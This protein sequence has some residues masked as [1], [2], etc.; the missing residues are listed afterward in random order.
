[1]KDGTGSQVP[2]LGQIADN[3]VAAEDGLWVSAGHQDLKF[4]ESDDTDWARIEETSYWYA[5]RTRCFLAL[6]G[7]YPP[8]GAIFEIGAGN[9]SVALALQNAGHTVVAMEPTVRLAR[10]ARSRGLK[11]VICSGLENAGF[12]PGTLANVGM[13]DVLEHIPSD[14]EY[15]KKVRRLMPEQGRL[16]CAVPAWQFLWSRED[17]AAEHLRRYSLGE[18]QEKISGAGFALEHSTYYFAALLAPIL[19]LRALPSRLGLRKA[20]T[21]ESSMSEHTLRPGLV[22]RIMQGALDLEVNWIASARRC[23]V[24]ASCAVVARAI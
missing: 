7:L 8:K 15:L 23:V 5:H 2:D 14:A 12:K 1:M 11:N 22:S 24:G 13:F 19:F 16:Y 21:A 3:L 6:I 9:G 20:R 17:E 10:N 18:L 4:I